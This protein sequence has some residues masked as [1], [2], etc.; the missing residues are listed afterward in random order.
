MSDREQRNLAIMFADIAGSTRLY[1]TLG[2]AKARELTSRCLELLT[3]ITGEYL[4]R[5]VKT[6]GDEVMC[7][8]P[9]ADQAAD[10]AVRM[11]EEVDNQSMA[12]GHVLKIRVGFHYG[13]VIQ[14]GGDV[15]GDAVNLA[16][17]MAA[18]AKA[19]Q[20]ITTGETR[21]LMNR[22]L[23]MDTRL[24]ITTTVKGKAKPVEIYELTWGEEEE[25]TVMGGMPFQQPEVQQTSMTLTFQGREIEVGAELPSAT[26]GR[27]KQN[28]FMV[29][30][31][32][33]S[34]IHARIEFR[35]DRFVLIDQSTNGTFI[36]TTGQADTFVHR[37]ERRIEG[38]GVIGLGRKV[39][40]NDP[41]AVY[42]RK[43]C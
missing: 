37:D 30:D 3:R 2:D 6:I 20:I 18:Q 7:T 43:N 41:L 24:L 4:G 19:D 1:E 8:F 29:P 16:A 26:L 10:A 35:R 17:R 40:P 13:D 32:M 33:S 38:D 5:V 27:G 12:W 23:Q 14:E 36:V 39:L 31:T 42:F 25:L 34:R 11:Q 28:H 9:S 15:F 22:M 21:D